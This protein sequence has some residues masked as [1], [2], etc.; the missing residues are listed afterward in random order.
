VYIPTTA[1]VATAPEAK[2]DKTWNEVW[3]ELWEEDRTANKT[4]KRAYD[5]TDFPE[6]ALISQP[7]NA[8]SLTLTDGNYVFAY[9]DSA[10]AGQ[11]VYLLDYG[12]NLANPVGFPAVVL[13]ITL[14]KSRR[15]LQILLF[16]AIIGYIR[17]QILYQRRVMHL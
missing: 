11:V 1:N 6:M 10:G 16:Q 12:A 9:D 13:G 14:T 2:R 7:S 5:E 15:S 3:E 4:E 8:P 17:D